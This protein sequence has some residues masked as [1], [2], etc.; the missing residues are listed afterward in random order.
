[1]PK[2]NCLLCAALSQLRLLWRDRSAVTAIAFGLSLTV[3]IGMVGLGTEAGTWYLTRRNAQNAADPAA[4]AG[5]VR[6]AFAQNGLVPPVAL[7]AAQTQAI[8]AATETAQ[9]NLFTTGTA[10]TTVTVNTP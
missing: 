2:A 8:A 5:A 9:R 4:Y 10:N 3:V 6:L 7:A 1:M